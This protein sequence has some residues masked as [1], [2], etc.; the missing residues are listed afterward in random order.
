MATAQRVNEHGQAIGPEVA[1]W[2]PRPMPERGPLTGRHCV[3]DVLSAE[4]A[5]GLWRTVGRGNPD[6]AWT[7]SAF[8]PFDR[9]TAGRT[10]FRSYLDALIA[11]PDAQARVI[12]SAQHA[13]V[14]VACFLRLDAGNG[15]AEVGHVMYSTA[16][17]RTTAGTEAMYLLAGHAFTLGYR[18]YEW[19]CDALNEP[20]RRTAHRLGFTYEGRFRQAAIYKG[21]SRDTDWFSITDDEWADLAPAYRA[22][23][24][25][26][27]F[28]AARQRRPLA[29]F[30]RD[31]RPT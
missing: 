11:L 28:V 19:K 4:H 26:A 6:S 3:V 9:T 8:G 1:G 5:D 18:R 20:S 12:L 17:Q 15:S 10:S 21:R 29:A 16:L 30:L 14:G 7:Y 22:W 25:P 2:T 27:N 13:P 23:L 31:A 24:D